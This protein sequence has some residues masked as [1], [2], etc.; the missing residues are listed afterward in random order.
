MTRGPLL[1]NQA[2]TFGNGCSITYVIAD[3]RSPRGA[4]HEKKIM[5]WERHICRGNEIRISGERDKLSRSHE[6]YI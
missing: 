4:M 1:T 3:L 2:A 6:F 5:S